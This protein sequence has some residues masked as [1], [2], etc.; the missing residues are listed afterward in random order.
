M[1]QVI[2]KREI[3]YIDAVSFL[4]MFGLEE[5]EYKT[6]INHDTIYKIKNIGGIEQLYLKILED[7][8]IK[9]E[10]SYSDLFL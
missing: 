3:P 9:T 8:I 4:E 10:I 2:I 6:I 7:T 1:H 5:L